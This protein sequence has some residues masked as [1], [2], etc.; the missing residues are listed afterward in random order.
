[1]C[2][3]KPKVPKP[4][5][6]PARAPAVTAKAPTLQEETFDTETDAETG[7][8]KRTGK[9]ALRVNRAGVQS[10]SQGTGLRIPR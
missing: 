2:F 10:N 6:A 4:A 7:K 9:A 1:M 8:K 3:G 5:P